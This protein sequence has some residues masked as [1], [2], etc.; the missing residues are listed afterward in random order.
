[1]YDYLVFEVK[2]YLSLFI[3]VMILLLSLSSCE[4]ES[5]IRL[6]GEDGAPSIVV[7]RPHSVE[8]QEESDA[9]VRLFNWL[10]EIYGTKDIK[11]VSDTREE[12]AENIEILVGQTSRE[13]SGA[14]RRDLR[15]GEFAVTHRGNKIVICGALTSDT[16][17]AVEYFCENYGE[18]MKSGVFTSESDYT[19]SLDYEIRSAK[20]DGADLADFTIIYPASDGLAKSAAD[21]L[22]D[23]FVT[24]T[25]VSLKVEDDSSEHGH[26]IAVGRVDRPAAEE[27]YSEKMRFN[28]WKTVCEDGSLYI[29]SGGLWGAC[30]AIDSLDRYISDDRFSVPGSLD[31]SSS[32]PISLPEKDFVYVNNSGQTE[33][34][35]KEMTLCGADI[36][37]YRV[38]CHDMGAG[39][40]GYAENEKYAAEELVKYIKFAT[41]AEL[42]IVTDDTPETERE[43]VVGATN[44]AEPFTREN[45]GREAL[46]IKT[47]GG[48]LYL[49]GG[50][51][52]GTIYAAYE[53]L[54]SYVGYR[55]FA[56][57]CEVIYRAEKIEI[58]EGIDD[59]QVSPIEYRDVFAI[60][61]FNGEFACKLK[62]NGFVRRGFTRSQGGSEEFAGGTSKFVHTI[63]SFVNRGDIIG[64]QPCLSDPEYLE[65]AIRTV[66][67]YLTEYKDSTIISVT[68][69]DNNKYCK[70]AEC[71]RINREE[72]SNGGTQIRFINAIADAIK[73]DFPD[74][75]VLTLAYMYSVEP[76][77]TP[78][79][80]NVI[81]ELCSFD[82]CT[83][84]PY[85]ACSANAEFAE[86]LKQ[87]H[88]LTD[89]LYIWDY[90]I[91]FNNRAS[92]VPY[93]NFDTI[94]EHFVSYRENGVIGIFCEGNGDNFSKEF[95]VLRDYLLGHLMWD[96]YISREEYERMIDEF[97]DAYYGSYSEVIR[98][99]FDFMRSMQGSSHF[100]LFSSVDQLVDSDLF[101]AARTEIAQWFNAASKL[102]TDQPASV[103]NNFE[104]LHDGFTQLYKYFD[105]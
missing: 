15:A 62:I 54:E 33:Y 86:Y 47:D 50:E 39:Y 74:A 23:R 73:D 61:T 79:R 65:T 28:E 105:Q 102:E 85:G 101:C 17:A 21:I 4:K 40:T 32:E 30:R 38:V 2:K 18:V 5:D 37:E 26:E 70:C 64:K 16:Y 72:G 76:T 77:K 81:I 82:Y 31:E 100:A 66:R 8:L 52:R 57:D 90:V 55:F 67:N 84:H 91:D 11:L 27:L 3:F 51:R 7:V 43:I 46:L 71:A 24:T 58:P 42:E 104:R 87:W 97:I 94:Y 80:D 53:F 59:F 13:Q 96:P 10:R 1:M 93:M 89:N 63:N 35:V 75:K 99:Y 68:Q 14:V 103:T 49:A 98:Q 9:A 56:S 88:E 95:G 45:F 44:R 78:P 25:G 60:D 34:P 20:I 6:L 12:D 69:N 83:A 41:G 92:F 22:H 29:A 36:S 19:L 48:K